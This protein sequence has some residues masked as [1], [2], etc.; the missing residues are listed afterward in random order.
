MAAWKALLLIGARGSN[1]LNRLATS[2][3][4]LA[5][6]AASHHGV[7][8][9]E[10][11]VATLALDHPACAVR[12]MAA[13]AMELQIGGDSYVI[14]SSFS[15]PGD[16]IG[17]HRLSLKPAEGEAPWHPVT[18]ESDGQL[19]VE[20]DGKFY[21]LTRTIRCAGQRITIAD[22]LSNT[23]DQD[24][25]ILVDHLINP[26]GAMSEVR[27]CGVPAASGNHAENPTVFLAQQHSRLAFVAE[28][29]V[30]RAQ[31]EAASDGKQAHAGLKHL[32]LPPGK[33]VTLEW[34]L[35]PFAET[36]D[37]FALVNQLRNDWNV[38]TTLQGPGDLIDVT[39]EPYWRIFRD[40]AALRELLNR[41]RLKVIVL[42]PWL[43]YDNVNGQ[44]GQLTTRDDYKRMMQ[45]VLRTVRSVDP[46]VRLL[47]SIEAPFVSLPE[48]LVQSL[49]EAVPE[50]KKQGYYEMTDAMLAI[51]KQHSQAWTRWADSIVWTRQGRANFE[52]YYRGLPMIALTVRPVLGNGQHAFLMDQARFLLEE[53]GMDGIYV[54][55]FTGAQHWHYGYSYDKWD[56][57]TVDIDPGNGRI[58]ARYSDLALAGTGS[59]KALIEYAKARGKLVVVNGHPISRQT[60]SLGHMAFNESE[61][62]FEPLKWLD[63]RPPLDARPCEAQLSSPISLGFRPG[64]YGQQGTAEY[65]KI[66]TKGAIA[67][68]R[69]GVL[70]FHY[71]TQ[72]PASGPGSGEYGPFNHMFPLTPL[73]LGEGFVEGQERIVTCV[74]RG[75]DW[76]RQR[77]PS[78]LLFDSSGRPVEHAMQPTSAPDGWHVDIKLADWQ[79][80]AVIE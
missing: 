39:R 52:L 1:L 53:V 13:G 80:I 12:Q 5:A 70:Y 59:R 21:K 2:L 26:G 8:S 19:R 50:P 54:D 77:A 9:A 37:Y 41:N 55:S 66:V 46:E 72:L 51:L 22:T 38:N 7:G 40:P 34:A 62:V 47:G 24:V 42:A 33:S 43:D 35:Y 79:Q 3:T 15:Y 49:Y 14:E 30:L 65:A 69:H 29:D 45:E 74:S 58:I 25:G 28:D 61:W 63:Q 78:I 4:V 44:T 10:E 31:F 60:Q 68:L 67:Y 36:A 73:R 48:D 32:G 16:A 17:H 64:R 6:I 23:G 75:F 27:L 18:S 71:G 76:P 20:A 11:P 56:G 57:L